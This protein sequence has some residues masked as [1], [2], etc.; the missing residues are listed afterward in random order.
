MK[1]LKPKLRP[2]HRDKEASPLQRFVARFWRGGLTALFQHLAETDAW[3]L[4]A[5]RTARVRAKA[6]DPADQGWIEE[7]L[8]GFGWLDNQADLKAV[9]QAR[10]ITTFEA[11]AQHAMSNLGVAAAD[12]TLSNPGIKESL[13]ARVQA[14]PLASRAYIEGAMQHIADAFTD[15]GTSPYDRRF[16]AGLKTEI[17]ATTEWQAQRFALTETGIAAEMAAQEAYARNGVAKKQWNATGRDTRPAHLEANGKVT[18]IR[19]HFALDG[20]RAKHPLDPELPAA[21]IVNCHCWLSPVVDDSFEPPE[22]PW[23]GE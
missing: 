5:D 10:G 14:G 9:M 2:F 18:E 23:E 7:L 16:L 19:G 22:H 17:G 13:L 11:A 1:T 3:R 21:Q 15:L 6:V 20:H 4:I 12:F 8:K